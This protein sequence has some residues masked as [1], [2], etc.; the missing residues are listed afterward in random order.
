[1][2]NQ[3]KVLSGDL[4]KNKTTK[5][6]WRNNVGT[7]G[8]MTGA[9]LCGDRGEPWLPQFFFCDFFYIYLYTF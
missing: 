5:K 6:Q 1:M 3:S 4:K 9:N 7:K 8:S 2:C